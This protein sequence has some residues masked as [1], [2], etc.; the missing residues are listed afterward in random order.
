MLV[1]AYGM[2]FL[3]CYFKSHATLGG[4]LK[5]MYQTFTPEAKT[6]LP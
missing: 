1:R 6:S 5:S 4:D 2:R 3:F